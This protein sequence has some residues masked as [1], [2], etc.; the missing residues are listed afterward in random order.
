ML[1]LNEDLLRAT[2]RFE[3]SGRPVARDW[4]QSQACRMAAGTAAETRAEGLRLRALA[5]VQ[6][7]V[8][9]PVRGT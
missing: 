1:A 5:W 2:R 6:G 4:A 3:A 9:R 8:S 7:L